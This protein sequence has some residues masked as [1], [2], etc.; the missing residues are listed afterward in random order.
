MRAVISACEKDELLRR[1]FA[2]CA[3]MLCQAMTPNMVSYNAL[4]SAC[5]KGQQTE[6]ALK[7]FRAMRR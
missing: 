2:V 4:I 6:I 7:V 1:A 3:D 5:E